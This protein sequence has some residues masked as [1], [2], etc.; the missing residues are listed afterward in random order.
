MAID[1]LGVSFDAHNAAELAKFWAGAL[2]RSVGDGATE[3]FASVPAADDA[4]NGPLLMFH[5]VPEGKTIKNRVHFDLAT[6]DIQVEAERLQELGAK[7]I[8]ALAENNDRW[9]GFVDPEGNE[10]DLVAR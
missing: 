1:V 2:N 6:A 8:R 7:Q 5:Q 10:F 3:Q 4:A 9:I